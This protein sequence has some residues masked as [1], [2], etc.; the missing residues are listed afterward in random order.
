MAF[1]LVPV[2]KED[3]LV[4]IEAQKLRGMRSFEEGSFFYKIQ[5]YPFLVLPLML[6]AMRKAQLSSIAMDSRAFGV[7][8]TRTW[9]DKPKMNLYDFLYIAGCLIFTAFI[10]FI[11]Y[12]PDLFLCGF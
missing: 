4:I 11:N 8:K 6:G 5:A 10:L 9:L 3:A 1:N 12:Q 7:Y 2:F